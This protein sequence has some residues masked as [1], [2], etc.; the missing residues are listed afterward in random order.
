[1]KNKKKR[2]KEDARKVAYSGNEMFPGISTYV[3]SS[4]VPTELLCYAASFNSLIN[5]IYLLQLHVVM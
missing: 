5:G 2:R 4:S 3:F 1:M